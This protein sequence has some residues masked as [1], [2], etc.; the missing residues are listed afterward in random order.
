[1]AC[2]LIPALAPFLEVVFLYPKSRLPLTSS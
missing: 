2:S 1:L